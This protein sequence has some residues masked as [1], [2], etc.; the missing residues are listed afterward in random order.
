[1]NDTSPQVAELQRQLLMARSP[2]ERVQMACSMFDTAVALAL[3]WFRHQRPGASLAEE[4]QFLFDRFYGV[5]F[6]PQVQARVLETIERVATHQA[7]GS[8]RLSGG[9]A[10]S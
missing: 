5:E 6:S 10:N 2:S 8:T 7:L 9:A 1:M 4:R 3:A